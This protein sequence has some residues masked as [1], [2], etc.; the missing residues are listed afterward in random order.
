MHFPRSTARAGH[1]AAPIIR[2]MAR[3]PTLQDFIND[4]LLRVPMSLD[5]VIDAVQ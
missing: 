4:E 3:M 2:P 1:A 5:L